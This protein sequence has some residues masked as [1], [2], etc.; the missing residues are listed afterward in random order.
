MAIK[1]RMT[2]ITNVTPDNQDLIEKLKE[3]GAQIMDYPGQRQI[4]T[5]VFPVV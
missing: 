2:I 1:A 3:K 4:Q 5:A